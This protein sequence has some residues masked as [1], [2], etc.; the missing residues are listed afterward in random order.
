MMRGRHTYMVHDENFSS[1]VFSFVVSCAYLTTKL[2]VMCSFLG[3]F[4]RCSI[5]VAI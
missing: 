2:L 4:M 5:D 3:S 1:L